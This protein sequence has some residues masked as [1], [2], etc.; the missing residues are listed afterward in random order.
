MFDLR[1]AVLSLVRSRWFTAGAVLTYA[2]GIGANL[3][4]FAAVDQML[5]RTMPYARPADLIWRAAVT[6]MLTG[7]GAAWLP[8]RRAA[9]TDPAV[10]L[11]AQ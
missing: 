7:T 4:V 6:L 1:Y 8:A 9:R 10:V 2:L 11:R 3:V 5:F